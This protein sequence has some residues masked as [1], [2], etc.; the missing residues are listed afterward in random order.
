[1]L[2]NGDTVPGSVQSPVISTSYFNRQYNSW[3][4]HF[5]AVFLGQL[6]QLF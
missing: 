2:L 4:H 3:K 5:T 1:M 6:S